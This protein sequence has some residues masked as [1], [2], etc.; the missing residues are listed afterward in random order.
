MILLLSLVPFTLATHL[1]GGSMSY[2]YLSKN[3]S[4]GLIRYKITLSL[5]RDCQQSSVPFDPTIKIGIYYSNTNRTK[6]S[7][8]KINLVSK[9]LVQP[10]GSTNCPFKPSVCIE[11]GFYEGVVEV[12]ESTQGYEFTFERCCRNIQNNL[13]TGSSDGTPEQGQTYYCKIPPTNIKNSSPVFKGVPSPYMCANDTTA[14]LNTALDPD[15][16]SLVYYF[17]K[18]YGGGSKTI[19]DPDPPANL[20]LKSINYNSGFDEN[21]PFGST[22]YS[23]INRSNGLTEYFTTVTGNYVVAIEVS[24]YRNGVFLSRVRL[25][26]QII[27]IN[28]PP[29]K[30]PNITSDKGKSFTIEAGSKLCF[31][32]IANDPDNDN[33]KLT[34]SGNIFTGT[35]GWKGPTA[36]LSAKTGKSNLVSEFCW[37]TSCDQANSTPYQFAVL[38]EDDGCPGKFNAVNFTIRVEPFVSKAFISGT[39]SLC[40]HT[41]ANYTANNLATKSSV[42]WEVIN[43]SIISGKASTKILVKWNGSNPGKV[44]MREISQYGC[45]G[46]W[47]ELSVTIIMSPPKPLLAG[48]DTVCLNSNGVVYAVS[49]FTP[50]L[51]VSWFVNVGTVILDQN[52]TVSITWP[53]IG[54]QMIKVI[55]TNASG[56]ISDTAYKKINVRKPKPIIEGPASIC[57]NSKNIEYNASG[58]KGSTFLWAVSGGTFS[59]A[60]TNAKVFINWGNAGMG[61]LSVTETDRFGCTSDPVNFGVNKTYIL[62]NEN[63]KGDPTVCEFEKGVPYFVYPSNGTTFLWSASGGAVRGNIASNQILVDWGKAGMGSVTNTRTAYDSVNNKACLSPPSSLNVIINPTPNASVIE[64][65]FEL[66]QLPDTVSYTINGFP[67]STYIWRVNGV[68]GFI[69]G[70]GTKTIKLAWN[71]PGNYTIDVLE[72]SKDSCWGSVVDSVIIVHPKPLSNIIQGPMIVCD[73]D[74]LGRGYKVNGYPNST[75]FWQVNQGTIVSG[76]DTDSAT[77]DWMEADP[78]WLKVVEISEFGCSGDTIFNKI[79]LDKLVV[80]M[81]VVSV[82]SPDDRMEIS[83]KDVNSRSIPRNFEIQRRKASEM[84]WG[85]VSSSSYLNYIDYPLNTDL[86][87]FN[88]RVNVNDLCNVRKSTD[89]HTNVWLSGSKTEDPYAVKMQFTPY[90]GFKNGVRK[91]L[92]YRSVSD[93]D[94]GFQIYDSFPNPKDLFYNNGLEGYLQCYRVAAFEEGGNNQIGWSNEVCFNFAPTIYIPNAFTPN[95]DG[96]NDHFTISA[97]AIK[98]FDIQIFDRWGEKIWESNDYKGKG[99]D[100]T[101]LSNPAQMDVYAYVVKL[102]DFKDKVYRMNGT[103]HL[104]R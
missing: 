97:G 36:S 75:Y 80:E 42:E 26:L 64:G 91:Y 35:G 30:K 82:G 9:R 43:G 70:Q 67:G 19:S 55:T 44:R 56:C 52:N 89:V 85:S 17:V 88:Y 4:N 59:S 39:N 40:Q 11:E 25:D 95:S 2:Q 76:Q 6:Y 98:T 96:L 94:G 16:D 29:N 58:Y 60:N 103:V 54:D 3:S 41:F 100:G 68:S 18:P 28:C 83:W 62:D 63:P 53:L 27:F 37:Q 12:P 73:P 65:D 33:L 34:P 24:E 77:I 92:L 20:T 57:P 23:N 10:P 31:N 87:A 86:N 78:A 71:T 79:T 48:I 49:N 15:G 74:F 61:G 45:P 50:G 101:Y 102:T 14:F 69:S 84:V 99:W 38:V 66:C 104:I 81:L 93:V 21:K 90:S 8:E 47:K 51:K 1:I 72:L 22:G 13:V 46:E 5:Y 32:V 7:T